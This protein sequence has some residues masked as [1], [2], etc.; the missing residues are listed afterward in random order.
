MLENPGLRYLIAAQSLL[1]FV[2]SW[3]L[4]RL[5]Q[6][7]TQSAAIHAAVSTALSMGLAGFALAFILVITTV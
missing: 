4:W 6:T 7:A 3:Y 2:A 1:F 5:G